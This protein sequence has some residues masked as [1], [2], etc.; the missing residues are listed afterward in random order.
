MTNKAL[1]EL[2]KKG[3]EQSFTIIFE[4]LYQPL[5]SYLL[6]YVSKAAD[7]EDIAQ[8]TFVKLWEKK[9]RL[10]L[11]TSVKSYVYTSAYNQFIDTYRKEKRLLNSLDQ[12]KYESLNALI[13]EPEDRLQQKINW[14]TKAVET[15]PN[16]CKTIFILHK[17]R[18]Y[19]HK[20]IAKELKISTKT[21]EAQLHIAYT[22]LRENLKN[23]P[24]LFLLLLFSKKALSTQA[25][26]R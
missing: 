11:Q 10:Q 20:E 5:V 13:E 22:R 2:L 18:G 4:A 25:Q 16:R 23:R 19:S 14:V 24:D 21:V 17:K 3:D 8:N 9:D 6:Q 12:L 15:L 7:A 26:E 1:N